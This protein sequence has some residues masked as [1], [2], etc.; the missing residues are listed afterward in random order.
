MDAHAA[1]LRAVTLDGAR[2]NIGDSLFDL[3]THTKIYAVALGKAAGRMAIALD[4]IIGDKLAGGVISTLAGEAHLSAKWRVFVGGHPAPNRASLE[5]AYA[6]CSMLR[7]ADEASAL[8]IFLVSGGG[9][10]LMEW[11]CDERITLDDLIAANRALVACG[12]G[13][14][15]I[16]GVRRA[17]SAVKGGGLSAC[18][19]RAAQ[20]TLIISDTN[21]GDETNVASGPTIPP[22]ED[23]SDAR[24]VIA[25][26]NLAPR[27]PASILRVVEESSS[28]EKIFP[29]HHRH[30]TLLSN[31]DAVSS[32]TEAARARGYAVETARDINEQPID[33]GC[34]LLLARLLEMRRKAEGSK[35]TCL[36]SGG[37][38][39]CP[40]RGRGTG[41]RNSETVLRLA[42][43]MDKSRRTTDEQTESLVAL[44]A[45][46]DGIDGNSPAAG[47]IADTLSLARAR[48][49]NLDA[50]DFLARSDS[51]SFFAALEDSVMTGATG[52]NVRDVRI[53]LATET[54][55]HRELK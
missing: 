48:F 19:P 27:L 15:E 36:I 37:E 55:R 22:R 39:A 6:A 28:K 43:E 23:S 40:A 34:A 45:G 13:I 32:A 47:A 5:A 7:Q 38:F 18:A 4:E 14:A 2:L 20:V 42:I 46:T 3:H 1:V 35:P 17:L 33:E 21:E 53:L 11:P 25:R 10:A 31:K 8:V 44:S 9:S 41:G 51:Y 12:A 30:F 52:T 50:R 16:N 49:L 26:F 29:T 24:D 54:Q